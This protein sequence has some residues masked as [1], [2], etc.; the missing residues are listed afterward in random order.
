MICYDDLTRDQKHEMDLLRIMAEHNFIL[1][2]KVKER[3]C[4]KSTIID[5]LSYELQSLGY[6]VVIYA[7]NPFRDRVGNKLITSWKE[8]QDLRGMRNVVTLFDE[9]TV[10][11]V[12][13]LQQRYYHWFP[14]TGF[15]RSK[16]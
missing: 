3:G 5:A 4:G 6:Y 14:M 12:Y 8:I 2:L 11:D 16:E 1:G 13:H 7:P 15:I 10:E 9:I